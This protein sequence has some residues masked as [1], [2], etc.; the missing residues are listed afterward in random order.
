MITQSFQV[1]QDS[2]VDLYLPVT[3]NERSVDA[4]IICQGK[5]FGILRAWTLGTTSAVLVTNNIQSEAQ[6]ETHTANTHRVY[7]KPRKNEFITL[8]HVVIIDVNAGQNRSGKC[9]FIAVKRQQPLLYGQARDKASGFGTS[10]YN[11]AEIFDKNGG[12]VGRCMLNLGG[13]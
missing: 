1:F 10:I 8:W 5:L 4:S 12:G 13:H 3:E 7:R 9:A 11:A 2:C 6:V